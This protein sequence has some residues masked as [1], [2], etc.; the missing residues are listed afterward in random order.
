MTTLI[1]Q[2]QTA[3]TAIDAALASLT[4][5]APAP[6]PPATVPAGDISDRLSGAR[7][8]E[9]ISLGDGPYVWNSVVVKAKNLSI[10][11]NGK[12]RVSYSSTSLDV[13]APTF[14]IRDLIVDVSPALFCRFNEQAKNGYAKNITFADPT[15]AQLP[16]ESGFVVE[17]GATGV[18]FENITGW[19]N[20]A[21][22]FTYANSTGFLGCKVRSVNEHGVRITSKGSTYPQPVG[23]WSEN[24]EYG[25]KG[26]ALNGVNSPKEDFTVRQC[27]GFKS[28]NDT[29]HG[30]LGLGQGAG[31]T[32]VTAEITGATFDGSWT[33]G[34]LLMCKDGVGLTLSSTSF[35]L[36][37]TQQCVSGNA[38]TKIKLGDG[39]QLNIKT[40]VTPKKNFV[41]L[42]SSTA[43]VTGPAPK[44]T[45]V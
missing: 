32:N 7:D 9:L 26:R 35:N 14:T 20:G 44:I 38:N 34:S 24:G 12:T 6:L 43:S 3:K 45:N 18:R 21:G 42:N 37:Q 8:D 36:S 4:S 28:T 29:F 30:Y 41:S 22:V 2:L 15:N 25:T 11:G 33:E 5:T 10:A 13:Q 1:E 17:I 16:T 31:S 27:T 23:C 40:G 19:F 39:N